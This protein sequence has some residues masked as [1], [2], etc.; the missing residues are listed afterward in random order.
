M[1]SEQEKFPILF[2]LFGL[3]SPVIIAEGLAFSE[4]DISEQA[5]IALH[6]SLLVSGSSKFS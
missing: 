1:S 6:D 3:D 5:K 2:T 4:P